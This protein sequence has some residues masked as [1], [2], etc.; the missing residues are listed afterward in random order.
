MNFKILKIYFQVRLEPSTRY[1]LKPLNIMEN[2]FEI[3]L[4]GQDAADLLKKKKF[5]FK[6]FNETL[7]K[8]DIQASE[9]IKN[10]INEDLSRTI[11]FKKK[12]LTLKKM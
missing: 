10:T 11:F 9:A 2:Q 4:N 8:T 6:D 5:L 1:V 7:F 12:N 3:I